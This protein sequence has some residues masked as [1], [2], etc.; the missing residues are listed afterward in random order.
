MKKQILFLI[1]FLIIAGAVQAAE[2]DLTRQ[3]RLLYG[4]VMRI[5]KI[6]TWPS[7]ISPGTKGNVNVEIRNAG[8]TEIRDVIVQIFPHWE[9][10]F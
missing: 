1:I 5:D 9:S 10:H 7:E 6:G 3:Q 8:E 2:L 4:N